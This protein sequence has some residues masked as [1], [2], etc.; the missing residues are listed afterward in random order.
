MDCSPP[1]SSVHGISQASI[2]EWAAFSFC[3][4]FSAAPSLL[5]AFEPRLA[6]VQL[7]SHA[8]TLCDPMDRS[9]PGFSVLL[10]LPGFAQTHVHGVCDAVQPSHPLLSLS[11]FAFNLSQHQC[12]PMG[13]LFTSGGQSIGASASASVLPMNIQ[14]WFLLGLTGLISLWSKGLSLADL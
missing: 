4:G 3:R 6:V 7:L 9:T 8:A 10:H 14:G 2:L 1:G 13:R 11:P 5:G 12:F